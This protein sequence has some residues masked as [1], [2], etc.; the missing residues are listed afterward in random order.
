MWSS[1]TTTS[2][3][4]GQ[5]ASN[6][7]RTWPGTNHRPQGSFR[8]DIW[9]EKKSGTTLFRNSVQ[10]HSK[11]G[12]LRQFGSEFHKKSGS[13]PNFKQIS[14]RILPWTWGLKMVDIRYLCHKKLYSRTYNRTVTSRFVKLLWQFVI[15]SPWILR[16]TFLSCTYHA[17]AISG[18]ALSSAPLPRV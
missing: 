2:Q 3:N 6:C 13:W 7:S 14:P 1:H 18:D 4:T 12:T 11:K 16:P 9:F 8:S 5:V 17:V 10:K 15:V